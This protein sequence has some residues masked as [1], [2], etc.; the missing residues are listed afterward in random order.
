MIIIQNA[1]RQND[2]N[3][4]WLFL[5][6][7]KIKCGCKSETLRKATDVF[8]AIS[9]MVFCSISCWDFLKHGHQTIKPFVECLLL[10][11]YKWQRQCF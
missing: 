10:H 6:I 7:I 4:Y 11:N 8:K 9:F 5:L 3:I 2:E 1:R